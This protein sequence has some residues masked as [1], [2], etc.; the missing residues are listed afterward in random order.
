MDSI[1]SESRY[2]LFILLIFI[3]IVCVLAPPVTWGHVTVFYYQS[4]FLKK[5]KFKSQ[6]P[7]Y[8]CKIC[9]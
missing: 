6:V 2:L 3:F 5:F 9:S 1:F 8:S 4:F 7:K